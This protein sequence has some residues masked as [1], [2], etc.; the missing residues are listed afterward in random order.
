MKTGTKSLL[1]GVHQ[2]LIHPVV[3]LI[4]WIKINKSVPNLKELFCIV[5]HDW[6]YWGKANMD[7]EAGERHPEFAAKI[8]NWLFG[9]E[10]H[11]FC[12]YHSRH[13][14][15]NNGVQPSELC[16]ADKLSITHE[17]WW[18]Y[19]PRAWLSG[20]LFEYRKIADGTGFMPISASH[21][22][23]YDWIQD[24]LGTLGIEKRGDVVP[25]VNPKRV[26]GE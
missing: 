3:V 15:R 8:A 13:Y 1:F 14:A 19:L 21:R 4:A 18:F 20:E 7:D 6:G 23:W 12:L 9:K 2:F 5:I 16:W 24:R 17:P 26:G 22:E 11:D 10:Y 25:Y